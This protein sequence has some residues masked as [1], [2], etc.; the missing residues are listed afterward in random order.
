MWYIWPGPGTKPVHLLM[1]LAIG[2]IGFSWTIATPG[3]KF[4]RVIPWLLAFR[5]GL[6]MVHFHYD[7]LI[8]RRGTPAMQAVLTPSA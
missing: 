6:G 8:W 5:F 4:L 7:G 2:T 1:L 3:G